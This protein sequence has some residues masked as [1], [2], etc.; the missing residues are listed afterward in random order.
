M[1]LAGSTRMVPGG[2]WLRL[3]SPLTLLGEIQQLSDQPPLAADGVEDPVRG[4]SV[5]DSIQVLSR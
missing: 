4:W 2:G 3:V 5:N 1:F